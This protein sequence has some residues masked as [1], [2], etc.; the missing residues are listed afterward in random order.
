MK[1]VREPLKLKRV[2]RLDSTPLNAAYFTK[3]GYL[4]DRPIVTTCGIFEYQRDDGSIERELRLPEDVFAQES[5]KSYRGKPIIFTHDAGEITKDNVHEEIIGTILSDGIRDGDNVLAD[6]VIHD[7]DVLKRGL[8][9]LSLGYDCDLEENPGTWNGMP[10]DCIQRNIRINHLA[11]VD[12]ARAGHQA[13]L[14]LDGKTRKG[15]KK[16][17]R[18]KRRDGLA[19]NLTPEQLQAAVDMYLAAHPDAVTQQDDDEQKDPVEEVR[20]NVDRRDEDIS[21][22][23]VEEIPAM[24]EEIKTLLDVIDEMKGNAD[25]N[26]DDGDDDPNQ[27]QQDEG[28]DPDKTDDDDPEKTPDNMDDDETQAPAEDKNMTMDSVERNFGEMY[29]IVQMAS[30]LGL[31]GY[32]P[33]N[34]MDGKK[35]IIKAINPAVKLDGKSCAYIDGAYNAA[36]AMAGSRKNAVAN[37]KALLG[38]GTKRQDSAGISSAEAARRNMVNRQLRKESK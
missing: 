31:T 22:V 2:S 36:V 37:T 32:V 21:A 10:Y 38:N 11:I 6:I 7:A 35:R 27:T 33:R 14:N 29:S 23:G 24:Q 34:V 12:E 30:K 25:M 15:E 13:R 4:R 26:T 9:E 3:E 5:L 16:N 19:E 28:D 18:K 20:Q 8:R 17:M 1:G